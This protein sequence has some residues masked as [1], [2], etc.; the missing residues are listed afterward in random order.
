MQY[1]KETPTLT[2]REHIHWRVNQIA[3]LSA[4]CAKHVV[5]AEEVEVVGTARIFVYLAC[6]A[7]S[8]SSTVTTD[9]VG[10]CS[11]KAHIKRN[12]ID[13]DF[14]CPW[15]GVNATVCTH[16][17]LRVRVVERDVNTAWQ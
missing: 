10:L 3:A 5:F 8:K 13:L 9:F 1:S 6:I 12:T 2:H 15:S 17:V 11:F 7:A 14:Q 16:Q 4:D